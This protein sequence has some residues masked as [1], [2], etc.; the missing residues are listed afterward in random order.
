MKKSEKLPFGRAMIHRRTGLLAGAIAPVY[1]EDWPYK[2]IPDS[3]L[4]WRYIDFFKFKDLVETS[5][6][7]LA[8]P[9]KFTDPFE[10]RL[11]PGNANELSKSDAAF[12]DLYR[13][14]DSRDEPYSETHRKLV[15]ILC[16]HRNTRE[17]RRMWDA[18]TKSP[19]SV[20]I[21]TSGKA[22]QRFTS[23]SLLKSAVK[24]VP[25]DRPRTE[26]DH[27]SL[28]FF[29]PTEY[30]FEREFRLLRQPAAGE[31][32]RLEDSEDEYRRVPIR[33]R[34]IIHRVVLHPEAEEDTIDEVSDLVFRYLPGTPLMRSS[35]DMRRRANKSRLDNRQ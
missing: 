6:L 29:K 7:Y 32:F 33:L 9:D 5:T 11:S 21:T 14:A 28:F 2:S 31:T 4:L 20:A 17:I 13:I 8:R 30:S 3:E 10:G 34:K 1:E 19:N 25:I 22:I 18:Y 12:R 26:F 35:M 15:F 16:W 23:P 27:S 24:Y